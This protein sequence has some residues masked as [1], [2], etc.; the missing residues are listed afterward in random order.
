MLRF[1]SSTSPY[2][3][4]SA[5][6]S[7]DG[8]AFHPFANKRIEEKPM[9]GRFRS[10]VTTISTD[11]A[12]RVPPRTLRGRLL[13]IL[14]VGLV[15][16]HGGLAVGLYNEV[17]HPAQPNGAEQ[18]VFAVPTE[19]AALDD[20]RTPLQ[21]MREEASAD[22]TGMLESSGSD[23]VSPPPPEIL[24]PLKILVAGETERQTMGPAMAMIGSHVVF[25]LV[26]AGMFAYAVRKSILPLTQITAAVEALDPNR[27]G[28]PLKEGGPLEV[29]AVAKAFNAMRHRIS[30]QLD[31]RIQVLSA[32]SHDMQTPITRMRL[33]A[34]LASDFPEKEKLLRDLDET[35]RLVREGIAYARNAHANEEGFALVDFRSFIECLVLDYQDTGRTVSIANSVTGPIVTKP[36]A[37][38][39]SLSNFIDNALKFAGAAEV[40]AIRSHRD[41]IIIAVLDRGPGIADELLEAVK[42]PFVRGGQIASEGIPGSGLGLAIAQQLAAT[43][44]ASL[45][46]RNRPDGGLIAELVIAPAVDC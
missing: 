44:G 8:Q 36:R 5:S 43:F 12:W 23:A 6:T 29:A 15:F 26:S 4:A 39:R 24:P 41:E 20:R 38:R 33:R 3:L 32:F 19:L 30:Q 46:L 2:D 28:E 9:T 27:P 25:L 31:E 10:S 34:E 40:S 17:R 11:A 21:V 13:I 14:S 37:L 18:Q 42:K 22:G 1:C 7:G 45:N 35:E 16:A